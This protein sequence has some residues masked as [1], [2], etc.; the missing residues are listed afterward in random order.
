MKVFL[1]LSYTTNW[2][3]LVGIVSDNSIE[4]KKRFCLRYALQCV[5]Y[6]IWRER[7]RC[8]H[9]EKATL[10]YVL[11]K[12]INKCIKNK[13]SLLSAEGGENMLLFCSIGFRQESENIL[14]ETRLKLNF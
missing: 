7:N 6:S 12:T 14:E 8:R 2:D 4:V 9:G 3:D 11:T 10:V 13:L 1:Q 5:I